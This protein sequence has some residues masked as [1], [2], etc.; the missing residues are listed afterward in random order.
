MPSACAAVAASNEDAAREGGGEY[1]EI[2]LTL[3]KEEALER[4]AATST[5]SHVTAV[6]RGVES[7]VADHGGAE[8]LVR[9]HDHIH[10][11]LQ[12]RP[13]CMLIDTAGQSPQQTYDEVK[14]ALAV[15]G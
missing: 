12:T 10:E 3:G 11:F 6:Q 1:H 7:I 14:A 2:L 8:L 5:S 15:R 4:F 13:S 9:V